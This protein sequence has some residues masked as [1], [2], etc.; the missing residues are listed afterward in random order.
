MKGLGKRSGIIYDKQILPQYGLR[1]I[2]R[3]I[4]IGNNEP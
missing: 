3:R 2:N 1:L 4:N